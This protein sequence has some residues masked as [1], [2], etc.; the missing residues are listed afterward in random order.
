[1]DGWRLTV[2]ASMTSSLLS[3]QGLEELAKFNMRCSLRSWKDGKG[4]GYPGRGALSKS[5]ART[6]KSLCESLPIC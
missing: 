2:N 6:E 5:K 4:G 3:F 1:M